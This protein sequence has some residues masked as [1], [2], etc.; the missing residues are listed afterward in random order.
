VTTLEWLTWDEAAALVGCPV[1]TIDWHKRQGRIR[2]RG[3]RARSLE[4]ASVED[5]AVWWH[6]REAMRAERRSR[7]STSHL[8]RE[9]NGW[10][11][12]RDAA[13][14][15]GVSMAAVIH[16]VDHGRLLGTRHGGRLWI[17]A[18][19]LEA[20][21]VEEA[22]WISI[23]EAAIIIG[24]SA[25]RVG[26]LVRTGLIEQ[27]KAATRMPSIDR[28]SAEAYA[29]VWRAQVERWCL[30]RE[31][32]SSGPPK[33][34]QVWFGTTTTALV[35]GI[36]TARVRQLARADRLPYTQRG[37]RRWFSRTHVE[38]IAAAR[39]VRNGRNLGHPG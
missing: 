10:V 37:A 25:S 11:S 6:A 31:Q 7:R 32:R 3:R 34:G 29:E 21:A 38:Q 9:L 33:D 22:R 24:C 20:H 16:R 18:E 35:L 23:T 14:R 19:D 27:R 13:D 39:S 8:R 12:T 4:R 17:R 15:L 28:R 30:Q 26:E 1:A 2:S 5:F 36:S